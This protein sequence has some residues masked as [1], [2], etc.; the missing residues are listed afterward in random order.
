[1]LGKCAIT[2]YDSI[3]FLTGPCR[4]YGQ[5]KILRNHEIIEIAV[6]IKNF[7]RNS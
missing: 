5:I 2:L 1:V 6:M 7:E 4:A 3:T